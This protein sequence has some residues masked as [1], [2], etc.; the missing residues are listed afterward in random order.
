MRT[1]RRVSPDRTLNAVA[2][3][4]CAAVCVYVGALTLFMG[5]ILR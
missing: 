5:V 4:A 2:I 3:A 1:H